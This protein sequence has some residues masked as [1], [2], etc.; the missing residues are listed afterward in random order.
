MY[1]LMFGLAVRMCS[2]RHC[3]ATLYKGHYSPPL[4][5]PMMHSAKICHA[6]SKPDARFYDPEMTDHALTDSMIFNRYASD[7][8]NTRAF[9]PSRSRAFGRACTDH[10]LTDYDLSQVRVRQYKHTRVQPVLC[11][12]QVFPREREGH[13][14]DPDNRGFLVHFL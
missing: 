11:T 13:A 2:H 7:N 14:G 8:T 4:T 6:Q 3:P 12:C 5:C 1:H 9:S 10:A